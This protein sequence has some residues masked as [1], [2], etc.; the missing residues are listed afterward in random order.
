VAQ[1]LP[2]TSAS[3]ARIPGASSVH[4]NSPKGTLRGS[5]MFRSS[6]YLLAVLPV[7][8]GALGQHHG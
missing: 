1:R 2:P 5:S 6:D 8:D 3:L 7:G 4:S